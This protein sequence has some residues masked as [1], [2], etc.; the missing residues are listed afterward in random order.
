M[1][2]ILAVLVM[3]AGL[4]AAEPAEKPAE[5][6]GEDL[7]TL[8][9]LR[10]EAAEARATVLQAEKTARERLAQMEAEAAEAGRRLEAFAAEKAGDSGCLLTPVGGWQCEEDV[11]RKP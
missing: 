11:N 10:A 3:A 5:L 9:R 4:L 8:M 6:Q 7:T 1:R 2:T